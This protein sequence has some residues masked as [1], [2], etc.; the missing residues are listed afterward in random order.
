MEQKELEILREFFY[1]LEGC[2]SIDG[3]GPVKLSVIEKFK[4]D[5]D[6]KISKIKEIN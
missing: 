4:K 1:R 3:P 5:A 6:E 2:L